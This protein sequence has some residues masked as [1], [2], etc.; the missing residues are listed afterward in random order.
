VTPAEAD[1]ARAVIAPIEKKPVEQRNSVD[2]SRLRWHGEVLKRY[3]HPEEYAVYP[4]EL[5]VLRLGDVAIASNAFEL[6]LEYG[7][8]MRARSKGLQTFLIQLAC[9]CGGYLPTE[10]AVAGGGYSAIP[11]SGLVGPEGGRILVDRTVD[12]INGLWPRK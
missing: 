2:I 4:M 3:E 1:A 6:F 7:I 11:E 9:G 5:H 12:A 10:R 8:Q